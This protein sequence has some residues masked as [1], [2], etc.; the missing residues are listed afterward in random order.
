MKFKVIIGLLIVG[1]LLFGWFQ[2]YYIPKMDAADEQELQGQLD[3]ETHQFSWILK[4]ENSYMG[5]AGNTIN[6]INSL[7]MSEIPKKFQQDP[8]EFRFTVNYEVAFREIGKER[9]ERAILYNATAVFAL[10]KNMEIIEFDFPDQTFTVTR[11]RVNDWFGE[12][13]STFKDVKVFKEK[14]Q[15]PIINGNHLDK[16]FDAYIGGES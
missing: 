8:E 16:W 6:L 7:P 5:S 12:D 4:Y 15:Q 14:V 2:F 13:L 9:V 3:P 10:I 11:E 1:V